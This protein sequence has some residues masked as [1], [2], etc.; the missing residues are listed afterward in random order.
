MRE[1]TCRFTSSNLIYLEQKSPS[2]IHHSGFLVKI[3]AVGAVFHDEGPTHKESP[4]APLSALAS[5]R[6]LK[7]IDRCV[8]GESRMYWLLEAC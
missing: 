1:K 6:I 5:G 8:K 2:G 3:E 4:A 7:E